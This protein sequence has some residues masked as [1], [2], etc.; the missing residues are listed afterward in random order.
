MKY[1]IVYFSFCYLILFL[2]FNTSIIRGQSKTYYID[3]VLGNDSNT[4][5]SQSAPWKSLTKVNSFSFQYNDSILFKSGCVWD[6][7]LKPK[8]SG[9]S[10]KSIFIDMYGGIDKPL[11]RGNGITGQATLYLNNQS[12][13][14]ISNLEITNDDSS[15]AGDRRG[16]LIAASNYGIVHHI[17]LKN[18]DVHD[19]RGT[20]G[21]DNGAK[22]TG[23]IGFET[24]A[25]NSVATRFDDILIE[26]CKIYNCENTG[27]FTNNFTSSSD[28]PRSAGWIKR[29]FSNVRIRNNTIHHISKNA[30]IIRLLDK[31]LVENNVCYETALQITGN[32]IYT[33]STDGTVF[34]YNEGYLNRSPDFDGSLYDADLRTSNCIFQYS[35]SHENAH[36]LFWNCTVQQDSGIIVRY[37][38][39]QGDKGFIF[40]VNYPHTSIYIYNNTVFIPSGESPTIISERNTNSGTRDYH[41]YNNIVYNLSPNATYDFRSTGYTRDI[42]YNVFYGYHPP[43]EPVDIH[44]IVSDPK[45]VSPGSGGI[46]IGTLAGYKIKAGSPCIGSGLVLDNH[47]SSDFW[48]V[49]LDTFSV[50]RGA[51]EYSVPT[52]LINQPN[53]N[54]KGF[55]VEQN[56][57][58]PF[59]P[60][61]TINLLIDKPQSVQLQIYDI[62]GREIKEIFTGYMAGGKSSFVWDGKTT[63]GD[64]AHSGVYF[65]KL[66]TRTSS[67]VIKMILVD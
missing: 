36:G 2:L 17:Y 67:S 4:G 26:G 39:S 50:D 56:F 32:T 59:N 53:S 29:C 10:S 58:N 61:T 63:S 40:C 65:A 3:N 48:G 16:V 14:E 8:G 33:I 11:F 12:Y 30:M 13:W 20:V 44:K 22:R 9:N 21:Q 18:L 41:F 38:I 52:G 5:L 51:S 6:G 62:Q 24:S 64:K 47:G 54:K 42:D 25:D 60:T 28:Y 19:V 7:Q 23:G 55:E 35:Y 31:G 43:A 15:G 46:G 49:P 66:S 45:L 27:L 37:N 1:K 34:Q 57:P